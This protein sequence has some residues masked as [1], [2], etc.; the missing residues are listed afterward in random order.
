MFG[1]RHVALFRRSTYL[2]IVGLAIA[3]AFTIGEARA[4]E[5]LTETPW[6]PQSPWMVMGVP[7]QALMTEKGEG[8]KVFARNAEGEYLSNLEYRERWF[9]MEEPI[10]V[11]YLVLFGKETIHQLT[12]YFEPKPERTELIKRIS[13]YLGEA[14]QG[15]MEPGAPSE[16]GASWV[17]DG[18]GYDLQDYG[19]YAE[20][21]VSPARFQSP[22]AYGLSEDT[23]V[24]QR[25]LGKFWTE[26]PHFAYLVGLRGEGRAPLIEKLALVVEAKDKDG[27][28]VAL[29][30]EVSRGYN[31]QVALCDLDGDHR[32]DVLVTVSTVEAGGPI[33]AAAFSFA[34]RR[35]KQLFGSDALPKISGELE[36]GYRALI[37]VEGREEAFHVDLAS[38][39]KAL[40]DAGVY[41]DGALSNPVPVDKSS[42]SSVLASGGSHDTAFELK[43]TQA[44]FGGDA[45]KPLAVVDATLRLVSGTWTVIACSVSSAN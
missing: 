20:M 15:A 39:K 33:Q 24:Y 40:D 31:P 27:E 14:E 25:R 8:K 11:E 12:L 28:H 7:Y 26:K 42:L 34:K 18:I 3:A 29:P 44:V 1:P 10:K 13:E 41:K 30:V 36:D 5:S 6:A 23:I 22:E 38:R 19:D 35:P 4:A 16:Y 21:Y 9:G 32:D 17:L 43:T 37:R 45:T 2:S